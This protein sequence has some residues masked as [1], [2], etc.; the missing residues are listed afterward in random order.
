MFHTSAQFYDK[1]YSFKDYR[2]EAQALTTALGN[3]LPGR[4]SIEVLDVGCGT[5]E[6]HQ[7]LPDTYKLTGF[8]IEQEFVDIAAAKNP[9]SKYLQADM[10]QF[11]LGQTY[12]AVV[13]MFSSIAY[14]ET[15]P[16]VQTALKEMARHVNPGGVLIV[17][18]WFEPGAYTPGF[19]SQLTV[20]EPELQ[21]CRMSYCDREGDVSLL[22]FHYSVAE[23]GKGMVHFDEQHRLGLFTKEQMLEAMASTGM[24]VSH[25]SDTG[26]PRGVYI[27][28][29]P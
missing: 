20:D 11:N 1:L 26:I 22:N 23:K 2:A 21:V 17:E 24:T 3:L 12:D 25:R 9:R 4:A 28:A 19:V 13:C 5:A 16:R 14:M 18:P 27:G 7:Y 10:H 29:K 8:D 6:H 15:L